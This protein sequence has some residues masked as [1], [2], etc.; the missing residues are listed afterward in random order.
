MWKLIGFVQVL[1]KTDI[2]LVVELKIYDKAEVLNR[3]G[4]DDYFENILDV[5]VPKT[6]F[7]V[8]IGKNLSG[9]VEVAAMKHRA[10]KQDV[11]K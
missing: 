3:L 8:K 9:L 5:E 7:P 2:D 1:G 6:I 11:Y 4:N 10:I